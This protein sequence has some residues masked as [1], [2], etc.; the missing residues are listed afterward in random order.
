MA[1]T[2]TPRAEFIRLVR[3]FRMPQAPDIAAFTAAGV[4][5]AGCAVRADFL[6][7]SPRAASGVP[8]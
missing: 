2:R 6:V 5:K 4:G 1:D 3:A 8:A 7:L